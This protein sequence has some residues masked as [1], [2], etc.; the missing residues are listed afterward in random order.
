MQH[1]DKNVDDVVREIGEFAQAHNLLLPG[2]ECLKAHAERFLSLGHCPCVDARISCPCDEALSDI[3]RLGRCECG[4]LIDPVR[5]NML[6]CD[7]N[8]DG[9]MRS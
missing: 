5:I 2:S 6:R 9:E 7:R 3:E 8:S 1:I 4:I